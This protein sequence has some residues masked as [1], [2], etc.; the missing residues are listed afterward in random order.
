M[1]LTAKT[2]QEVTF[3]AKV[4]GYDPTEVDE[5]IAAVA[6]GVGELQ[7]RLHRAIDR[8]GKAEQQLAEAQA[9]P[10]PQAASVAPPIESQSAEIGKVWEKAVAAAEQ[11]VEEAR[12]EAQ[13]LLDEAHGQAEMVRG[14][15]QAEA[16]RVASESQ[17][18]MRAELGQLEGVRDTLHVD[19]DRLSQFLDAEKSRLRTHV[20]DALHALDEYGA[21]SGSVPAVSEFTIPE[22][23]TP[24]WEQPQSLADAV[25]AYGEPQNGIASY[26]PEQPSFD[27]GSPV[28]A[29]VEAPAVAEQPAWQPPSEP[30][31][32]PQEESD[33]FLAELRRAVHDDQPLGPRE[34]AAVGNLYSQDDDKSGF[35]RRK[36]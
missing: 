1:E 31:L 30:E 26:Q 28:A 21:G 12:R 8:A 7:E 2:L 24:S 6:A 23:S 20:V 14:Q 5:F 19:V 4:R 11:A 36:K 3:G 17:E 25:E 22:A 9:H 29:A 16:D 34:D 13:E 33:P 32:T 15:A 35:F 18:Q 10:Q 27:N